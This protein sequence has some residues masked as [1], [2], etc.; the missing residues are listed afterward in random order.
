ML[1]GFGFFVNPVFGLLD[2]FPDCIGCILVFFGL[3]RL[4]FFDESVQRARKLFLWFFCVE[5]AKLILT[6]LT[7]SNQGSDRLAAVTVALV[8]EYIFLFAATNAFF[9][10]INYF[11]TRNGFS[12]TLSRTSGCA[13]LTYA[14][15][16]LRP[17]ATLLPELYSIIDLKLSA[18]LYDF[19]QMDKIRIIIDTKPFVTVFLALAVTVMGVF[20]FVSLSKTIIV[21]HRESRDIL[22]ERY[23]SEYKKNNSK[24]TGSRIRITCLMLCIGL[25]FSLDL[26]FD[27]VRIV[28]ASFTFLILFICTFLM[29]SI[30][31]FSQTRRWSLPAFVL[32]AAT[33]YFRRVFVQYDAIY[34]EETPLPTVGISAVLAVATSLLSLL[35]IRC[36]FYELRTTSEQLTGKSPDTSFCWG[37]YCAVTLLRAE[38]MTLPYT[39]KFF[40]V[41][42]LFLSVAFVYCSAKAVLWVRDEDAEKRSLYGNE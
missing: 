34:L 16:F 2:V 17:L 9:S 11:S 38:V 29:R 30:G 28:P 12:A 26:S 6:P 4:A 7:F 14:F 10:G 22:N 15:F 20:W 19:E 33:E 1:F 37:L 3:T 35:C 42:I 31:D 25:A 21:F 5:A 23:L 8:L 24:T 13:F 41:P 36:F 39:A 32:V 40:S 18:D 27:G